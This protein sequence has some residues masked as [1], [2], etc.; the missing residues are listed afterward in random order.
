MS[1]SEKVG[2]GRR[3]ERRKDDRPAE[4]IDAAIE[5]FGESGFGATRLE[6]VARRAGVSKGTVF[7]YFAN[8]EELFRAVAQTVLASK[9]GGVRSVATDFDRPVA[10]L[11][12]ALLEQAAQV[13]ESRL[14]AMIR[15]LIAEAR[16]FPDLVRVWHDEVASKMLALVTGAIRAGQDRG[17]IKAGDPRIF[18]ISIISPMFTL[19][20]FRE[21]F[22]ETD[23]DLPDLGPL[24]R[25]HAATILCGML[26]P[27]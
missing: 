23:I 1:G 10:E 22:A 9:L 2:G 19:A 15:L 27:K 16:Q 5:L 6:D 21:V 3:R 11:I 4:I 18:A 7:V 12:P 8:K 14:P 13:M 25:Q 20:I 26:A 17:E 24:A